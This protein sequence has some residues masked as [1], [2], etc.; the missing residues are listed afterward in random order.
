MDLSIGR[1]KTHNLDEEWEELYYAR[2]FWELLDADFIKEYSDTRPDGYVNAWIESE[3]DWN[4]LIEIACSHRDY[5]G[6]Y[7]TVPK[8]L[9]ARDRFLEDREQSCYLLH[10]DW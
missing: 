8:L 10:A 4:E 1:Q 9:E 5:W 6:T 7:D 3:E 2:K